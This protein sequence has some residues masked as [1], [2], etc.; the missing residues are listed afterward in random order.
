MNRY[1]RKTLLFLILFAFSV[2][3][4][5]QIKSIGVPYIRNFERS[6]YGAAT[7]NWDI[8]Q[9]DDG[10]LYFANNDGVLEF[11]GTNWRVYPISN[12]SIPRSLHIGKDGKVWVGA[13]DEFGYLKADKSGELMYFSIRNLVPD[14]YKNI[15]EVWSIHESEGGIYFQAFNILLF[16][17]FEEIRVIEGYNDYHFSFYVNNRLFIQDKDEGLK[18]LRGEKLYLIEGGETFIDDIEVWQMIPFSIDTILIATQRDGLF[19]YDGYKIQNYEFKLNNYLIDKQIFSLEMILDRY[20]VFGTIQAGLIVTDLRGNLVQH[21]DKSKG[22]QNNTILSLFV[23]RNKQIWLGLDN[24]I[25]FIEIHSAFTFLNDALGIEGTGYTAEL[26]K[27]N[28]YLG[29]NQGIRVNL[30]KKQA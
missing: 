12:Q 10:I 14:N 18:E 2:S 29:T 25:D 24:G 11:D 23:D 26:Y 27:G 19:L 16:Y 28:L 22:L 6:Q 30:R 7:Q 4:N 9:N 5:A 1:C 17:N 21:I 8:V 3:V 15:G 13:Y 20:L